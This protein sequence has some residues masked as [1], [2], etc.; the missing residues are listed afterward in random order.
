MKKMIGYFAVIKHKMQT[1]EKSPLS[2]NRRLFYAT[3]LIFS[4]TGQ[5]QPS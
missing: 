1:I 5:I 4:S 2:C 3:K